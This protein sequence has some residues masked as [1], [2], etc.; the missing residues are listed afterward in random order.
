MRR[1]LA[2]I[3]LI[4]LIFTLSPF[5][6]LPASSFAATGS[7]PL[8]VIDPGHGGRQ[9]GARAYG[10]LEKNVNLKVALRLRQYLLMAGAR[11]IMTRTTDRT[12]SLA[13]RA[14]IANKAKASRFISIH[15]NSASNK[16]RNG[17]ETYIRR[18][19]DSVS[20]D[21]AKKIHSNVLAGLRLSNRKV[22]RANFQVLKRTRM[23]AV[24]TEASF[25]SNKKQASKLRRLSYI[26]AEAKA[27]FYGLKAHMSL[28]R[29]YSPLAIQGASAPA[30]D[31][32]FPKVTDTS[33]YWR[34]LVSVKNS[35]DFAGTASVSLHDSSGTLL[36]NLNI[37]LG[38]NQ[39]YN[40]YPKD[41]IGGNFDGSVRATSQS[42]NL[43]GQYSQFSKDNK[44]LGNVQALGGSTE[45]YAPSVVDNG[46]WR[47]FITLKNTADTDGTATINYYN[48]GGGLLKTETVN[49]GPVAKYDF[50]P[51][52][53]TGAAFDGS[54][55]IQTSTPM[56]GYVSRI[57]STKKRLA[58]APLMTKASTLNFAQAPD[59]SIWTSYLSVKNS[60]TE[61]QTVTISAFDSNG[62]LLKQNAVQIP[63]K[64]VYEDRVLNIIGAAFEGAIKV[65]A[66][67]DV[68]AAYLTQ[69]DKKMQGLGVMEGQQG[70]Q[71]VDFANVSDG[72]LFWNSQVA[73]GN[74]AALTDLTT[75][76]Y[77]KTG[78]VS[79]SNIFTVN[80]NGF[81]RF[82]PLELSGANF[83]G[84][85]KTGS[86]LNQAVGYL[87]QS[88]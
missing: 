62:G 78:S 69:T 28:G 17:T 53:M 70:M 9:T 29:T 52:N 25:I 65:S 76:L 86:A 20:K 8:I 30:A 55:D 81:I 16:S 15:H 13:A 68:L 39:S 3:L 82:T 19:L 67:S 77:T 57:N 43:V 85:V 33:G 47:T 87:L 72:G 56:A 71:T 45:L 80:E 79:S 40:F 88:R 36:T 48:K 2:A 7:S 73:I 63:A 37:E 26:D 18:K 50:Y 31:I 83:E 61:A 21:M 1:I 58:I 74:S 22:R 14:A 49:I 60:S 41:I 44:A 64:A 27:I 6:L 84:S 34:G 75:Y 4:T 38:P 11:V 42:I 12:L 32:H 51:M 24:L 54:I 46:P 35:N 59:N 66:S 10:L 23:P 5:S